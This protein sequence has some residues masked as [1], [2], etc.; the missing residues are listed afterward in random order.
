[1]LTSR[2]VHPGWLRCS[3]LKSS[4]Y[5]RSSRLA[6]RAPRSAIWSSLS[7]DGPLGGD[8]L[9]GLAGRGEIQRDKQLDDRP[10]WVDFARAK[11]E[12][13]AARIAVMAVVKALA[14]GHQR[15]QPQVGRRVVEVPVSDVVAQPVDRRRHQEHRYRR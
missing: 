6:I 14:A 3:F 4:R 11:A 8:F 1:M 15:Q 5:P 13:R 7:A 2:A 9:D 10:R 12:L